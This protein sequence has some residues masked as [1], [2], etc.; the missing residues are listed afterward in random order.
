MAPTAGWQL[1]TVLRRLGLFRG[2][3]R[4]EMP[5]APVPLPDP[6]AVLGPLWDRLP[7]ATCAAVR[8]PV[9]EL[10]RAGRQTDAT[11]CGSAVLVM[12]AAAGDPVLALWLASGLLPVDAVGRQT[13]P[14]ELGAAPADRLAALADARA[15]DRFAVLQRV[16]KHRTNARALLGLP[17]PASLGTPPWGAA[18]VARFG[19]LRYGHEVVDDTDPE[20]LG[21]VLRRIDATLTRGVPVPLYTGGDTGWSTAVPRHVVLAVPDPRPDVLAIWEPSVG[22][23]LTITPTALAT[24]RPHPALGGWPHLTWTLLPTTPTP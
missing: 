14:P 7:P 15:E 4:A 10:T 1:S 9:R 16:V 19:G 24:G 3:D 6:A 21:D 12:L 17:W 23:V 13:H 20:H 8:D 22:R 11:T 2:P 5:A 18:R